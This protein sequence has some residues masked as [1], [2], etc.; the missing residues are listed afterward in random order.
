MNK[1]TNIVMDGGCV[2]PLAKTLPSLVNNMWWNIVMD[3]WNLDKKV[4]W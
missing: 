4:T 1:W 2:Q 3:D